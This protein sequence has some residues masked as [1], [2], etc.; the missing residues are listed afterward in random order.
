[1]NALQRLGMRLLGKGLYELH[2]EL[3]TRE[4]VLSGKSEGALPYD[5]AAFTRHYSSNVWV[6]RAV[7][8][9]ADTLC[10]LPVEIVNPESAEVQTAHVLA[11]L[12]CAPNATVP[13]SE[14]WQQWFIGLLL[15]GEVGIEVVRSRAATLGE[16][17]IRSAPDFDVIVPQG[18]ARR[19]GVVNGYRIDDHQ[20][21]A[22]TLP[23]EEFIHAK[24]YNPANQ[25]RGL[26][27]IAAARQGILLDEYAQAWGLKLFRQGARPDYVVISPQALTSSERREMEAF[28]EREYGG[29]ENAHKPLVLEGG[30]I[31]PLNWPPKDT[32]WLA[33]RQNA[34]E[35]I[36]AIFGVPDEIMGWGRDT[37]ENFRFSEQVFWRLT[38][39]PLLQ[40]RDTTLTE[41]FH[42]VGALDERLR[43]ATDTSQVQAL[44]PDRAALIDQAVKLWA[45]GTPLQ[46]A[47]KLLGLGLSDNLPG[48]KMGYLP[49][50]L[51]P[52]GAQSEPMPPVKAVTKALTIRDYG[53]D[54]HA[55]HWLMF[56]RG[57]E[58]RERGMVRLVKKLFQKERDD[59]LANVR[60]GG[61]GGYDKKDWRKRWV[62]ELR[63]F[64]IDNVR[65]GY[66]HGAD[67]TK[68]LTTHVLRKQSIDWTLIMPGIIDA[69]QR[70]LWDFTD[71]VTD[72]TQSEIERIITQAATEG[73]SV[74]QAADAIGALYD[75][76]TVGRAE[77]IV[78]TEI[79]KSYN[80]GALEGYDAEGADGK[81]WMSA[82]DDR[83]RTPP[84]SE[85]DHVAQHGQEVGLRDMFDLS[86]EKLR[87]PGDPNGSPGNIC[88]CR[89][90]LYPVIK[91]L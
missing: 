20:A 88:N 60:G 68:A 3:L 24:F 34:R 52:A 6:H 38:L 49:M 80:F 59:V 44:Q 69:I 37:Y 14:F 48:T 74:T 45:M 16:M 82:L 39:L 33:Q 46:E 77:C 4:H 72:W 9:I 64:Y 54:V 35:E 10:T 75:G 78:R 22:Y 7:K 40:K 70:M 25:W 12:L 30:D 19:Y 32:E 83:T 65:A 2:P 11:A 62:N 87:F 90:A 56:K 31:K 67:Q 15:Q 28:L 21:E 79:V 5:V 57:T 89:C 27:V 85:F 18:G 17:W 26:S 41:Y 55:A 36:G 53:S 66:E 50:N 63:A 76:F 1:M 13:S 23:P 43:V 71:E 29:L 58:S 86:G 51:L 61:Q 73:W 8:S 81:G 47:N 42:R 91:E 84:D